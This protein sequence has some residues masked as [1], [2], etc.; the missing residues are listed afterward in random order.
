MI[1]SDKQLKGGYFD[2][3][4]GFPN[5]KYLHELKDY[6][7]EKYACICCTQLSFRDHNDWKKG[8]YSE[9]EKKLIFNEWVDFLTN[10]PDSNLEA[11]HFNHAVPQ[12]LLEAA[13]CQKN[14][15]E[16][17]LKW[18]RYSDLTP[19]KKLEK[20]Q[21]LFLGGRGSGVTDISVLGELKNL[22]VLEMEYFSKIE[23]YSIL[24]NLTSLEQLV[25]TGT[26][27]SCAP[28][29]DFDF[30]RNMPNLRSIFLGRV[31]VK[32]RYTQDELDEL[33]RCVPNLYDIDNRIWGNEYHI[34]KNK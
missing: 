5:G 16:L 15:K 32:K 23:D 34:W 3:V 1:L 24:A 29:K 30:L 19:L 21:Y 7:G 6:N 33:R 4:G 10:N 25:I 22:V 17:R 26:V 8:Y 9:K 27:S 28:M 11:I 18:G 12:K 2:V 31:R 20:L 13:C 14:L